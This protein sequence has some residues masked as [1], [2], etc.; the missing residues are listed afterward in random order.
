MVKYKRSDQWKA[1]LVGKRFGYLVVEDVENR[2]A[3]CVCDCGN[4]RG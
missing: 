3:K 2:K 1:E 4:K